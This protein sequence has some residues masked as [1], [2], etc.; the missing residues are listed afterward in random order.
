MKIKK[1]FLLRK[2]ADTNIVI[3]IGGGNNDRKGMLLNETGSFLWRRLEEGLDLE[4]MAA[5]LSKEYG[6]ELKMAQTDTG[7]FIEAL[8][9]ADMLD[10]ENSKKKVI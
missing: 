8:R 9:C 4:Q 6:I 7:N 5:A 10:R 3:P 2:I 1:G